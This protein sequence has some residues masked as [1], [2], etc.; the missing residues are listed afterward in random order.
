MSSFYNYVC[1]EPKGRDETAKLRFFLTGRL[2]GSI[3]IQK[4]NFS[5][6]Q[7]PEQAKPRNG[8]RGPK[9]GEGFLEYLLPLELTIQSCRKIQHGAQD[10]RLPESIWESTMGLPG[11]GSMHP[12]PSASGRGFWMLTPS[13]LLTLP[14]LPKVTELEISTARKRI[15]RSFL[16]SQSSRLSAPLSK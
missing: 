6:T 1:L 4:S 5:G 14:D 11:Y 16:L 3:H 10:K 9:L 8:G 7:I 13:S 15:Q 2:I 12:C